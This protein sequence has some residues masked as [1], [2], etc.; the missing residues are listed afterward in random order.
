MKCP[1]YKCKIQIMMETLRL[2]VSEKHYENIK[3]KPIAVV[4]NDNFPKSPRFKSLNPHHSVIETVKVYM[5]KHVIHINTS[6]SMFLYTKNKDHFCIHC[7]E[8]T[9]FGKNGNKYVKCLNCLISICKFCLK[10][11]SYDHFNKTNPNH[12]RVYFRTKNKQ[13]ITKESYL[14]KFFHLIFVHIIS[15]IFLFCGIFYIVKCLLKTILNLKG[16]NSILLLVVKN[17]LFYSLLVSFL[18]F[19]LFLFVF[20]IPFFPVFLSI[21]NN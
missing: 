6:E 17:I 3:N 15:Y 2:I 4:N 8:P 16:E 14:A 7:F 11:Y 21:F 20:L 1:I 9:L 19:Q 18:A 10:K 12:C 13:I 5:K